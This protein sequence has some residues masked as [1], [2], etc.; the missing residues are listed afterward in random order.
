MTTNRA[1][2]IVKLPSLLTVGEAAEFVRIRR[3]AFG[4]AA[5]R[6]SA[7]YQ[8]LRLPIGPGTLVR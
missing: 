1:T 7:T 4:L 2:A 5:T 6:C 3:T 8:V